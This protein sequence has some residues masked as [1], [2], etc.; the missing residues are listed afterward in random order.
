MSVNPPNYCSPFCILALE[1]QVCWQ[2]QLFYLQP[3]LQKA[4]NSTA[5]FSHLFAASFTA[6]TSGFVLCPPTTSLWSTVCDTGSLNVL[7]KAARSSPCFSPVAGV[8]S[9]QEPAAQWEEALPRCY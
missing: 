2:A 6:V 9:F 1:L 5:S 8:C 7:L 3:H 4:D